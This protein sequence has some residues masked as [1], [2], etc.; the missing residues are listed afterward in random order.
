MTLCRLLS[1][2]I[3]FGADGK[4]G[5]H[6][7]FMVPS[8]EMKVVTT[9]PTSKAMARGEPFPMARDFETCSPT[10]TAT[11]PAEAATRMY[12]TSRKM[13]SGMAPTSSI[14]RR[15]SS[16]AYHQLHLPFV[17]QENPTICVF[18]HAHTS[19]H[20]IEIHNSAHSLQSQLQAG[21]DILIR[22]TL[23]GA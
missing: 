22:I 21:S 14:K 12:Q 8:I 17:L 5:R 2:S 1:L 19:M 11:G 4:V 16:V 3:H 6:T 13:Y 9:S 18:I 15:R 7:L 10:A 20:V 23:R